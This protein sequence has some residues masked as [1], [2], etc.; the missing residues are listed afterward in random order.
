MQVL[1]R[2][3]KIR[4][5]KITAPIELILYRKKK[6]NKSMN[7]LYGIAHACN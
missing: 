1:H 2:E 6:I 3:Q 4:Q 5:T 7:D